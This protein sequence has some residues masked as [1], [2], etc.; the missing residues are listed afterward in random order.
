MFGK[1]AYNK[2]EAVEGIIEII[3]NNFNVSESQKRE[4]NKFFR[5]NDNKNCDRIYSAIKNNIK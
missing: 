1:L 5:Y 2:E 3:E 4:R